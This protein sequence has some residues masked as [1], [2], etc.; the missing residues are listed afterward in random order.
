M[1]VR[2]L[3]KTSVSLSE[4]V[5]VSQRQ[6]GSVCECVLERRT[7]QVCVCLGELVSVRDTECFNPHVCE[8]VRVSECLKV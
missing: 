3:E 7:W 2:V 4:C 1:R 6:G 5:C 8:C